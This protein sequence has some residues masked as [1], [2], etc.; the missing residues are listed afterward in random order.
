VKGSSTNDV[1]AELCVGK[2]VKEALETFEHLSV[3][4][5]CL[6]LFLP[7]VEAGE[8]ELLSTFT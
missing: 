3:L 7:I 8:L 6:H 1:L 4:Y 2:L 5:L